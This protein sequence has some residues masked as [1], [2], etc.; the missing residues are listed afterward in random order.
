MMGLLERE[1]IRK[2]VIRKG[3][4]LEREFIGGVLIREKHF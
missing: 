1:L 4:L 2:G 3:E